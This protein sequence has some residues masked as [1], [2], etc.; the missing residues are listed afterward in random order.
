M[1]IEEIDETNFSEKTA[2][3]EK[4]VELKISRFERQVEKATIDEKN[5][6]TDKI[7]KEAIDWYQ[8]FD[9]TLWAYKHLRDKQNNLLRLRGFQDKIINDKHRFVI[10]AGANQ[11]GKTWTIAVKAI[12]HA[13][14]VNNAS[15]L[16]IS[17]SEQQAIMILDEIKWMMLRAKFKF[18]TVI[19]EVE[20][21][22][23]L[24][25][26]NEDKQGNK[27]GVSVIRCLPP[28]Q[29]VYA[30]PGTLVICDEIGFWEIENQTQAEFFYKVVVSRTNETSNWK[31]NCICGNECNHFTMGQIMCVSLPNG[32]QG[33]LW[34]LFKEKEFNQYRYSFLANPSNSYQKYIK[35][36]NDPPEGFTRDM[37]DSQYAALFTSSVGGFITQDEWK[38]AVSEYPL[39]TPPIF[40]LGGDFAG[41]DTKGRDVDQSIL[42]GAENLKEDNKDKIRICYIKEFPLRTKKEVIYN[43][44][45]L[46]K[47]QIIKFAYDRV[48]IGDSVKND[49]IERNIF[50]EYQIEALTY[51]LPNK[52]E[53]YYNLK[54]LFE[55]RKIIVSN[56]PKLKEQLMGLRFEKPEGSPHIKVHHKSEGLHDDFADA[57]ANACYAARI[58]K[59]IPVEVTFVPHT[60]FSL[61]REKFKRTGKGDLLFC[62]KC[63]DYHWTS[64]SHKESLL[65]V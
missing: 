12:H 38:D 9:P 11:I 46:F 33:V 14:Y 37:F 23:E 35:W 1:L 48:G 5:Q 39:I 36:R 29:G 55:Q 51:S 8:F 50:S 45:N 28:T 24:H 61:R 49:L 21:R 25:L 2:E 10:V 13:T 26:T 53:V 65:E 52:S 58:L 16:I 27:I 32:Q 31:K 19:D 17:R 42:I 60:Q 18:D 44:I 15:V 59:G 4:R 40:S 20:N 54:H 22:T 63:G 7:T 6:G 30:Y 34:D 43:E 47:G 57:L 62:Q 3:G 56:H 64:E 41:E